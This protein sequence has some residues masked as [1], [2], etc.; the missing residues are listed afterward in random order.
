MLLCTNKEVAEV[1]D[2]GFDQL[3]TPKHDYRCLDDFEWDKKRHPHLKEKAKRFSDGTLEGLEKHRLQRKVSLRRDMAVVLQINLDIKGGLCNG[4]QGIICGFE[5]FDETKL[6]KAQRDHDDIPPW[7]NLWGQH[8]ELREQ[9][10]RKFMSRQKDKVWP[11]V[12]FHNRKERTIFPTCIITSLGDRSPYS[13]LHRTQIPLV[14]G[15][16]MNVH[17]SQ[18]MTMERVIVNLTNSFEKGQIYVALSRTPSLRGLKIEGNAKNLSEGDGGNEQVT[19]FPREKFE[20]LFLDLEKHQPSQPVSLSQSSSPQTSPDA[21]PALDHPDDASS[22][23]FPDIDFLDDFPEINSLED[24]A[25][26]ASP[27]ER[28]E[29]AIPDEYSDDEIE[30][31]SMPW[32]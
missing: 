9:Q 14:H 23:E 6:P 19:T 32:A 25:K 2:N 29:P 27:E 28:P 22:D 20:E 11:R 26:A 24:C 7:Q 17:K 8:A 16:A 12:R 3:K 31:S 13:L 1:N 18:G 5:K 4:S 10:I 30:W 15:W 21:T